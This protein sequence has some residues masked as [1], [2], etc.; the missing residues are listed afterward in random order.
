M[1]FDL[2]LSIKIAIK[3]CFKYHF[4]GNAKSSHRMITSNQ[5]HT[6]K[7]TLN[8]STSG[9][10][11]RARIMQV[12]HVIENHSLLVFCGPFWMLKKTKDPTIRNGLILCGVFS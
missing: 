7:N 3:C 5:T 9:S 8:K 6:G 1:Y 2:P 12:L 11:T 10:I 4:K